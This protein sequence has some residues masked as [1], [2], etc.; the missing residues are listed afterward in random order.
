MTFPIRMIFAVPIVLSAIVFAQ[1]VGPAT[2]PAYTMSWFGNSFSG[3]DAWMQRQIL[4]ACVLPDG[5]VAAISYWDERHKEIG[6]YKDGQPVGRPIA[7][8]GAAIATDGKFLYAASR[9]SNP[10]I[11]GIRRLNLDGTPAPWPTEVRFADEGET[12]LVR[13]IAAGGGELFICA[14]MRNEVRV[15]NLDTG[16][17]KRSLPI[18]AA[19]RI[20]FAPTGTLWIGP[21]EY[22][23]DGTPTGR[24]LDGITAGALAIDPDGRLVVADAGERHQ[25]IVYDISGE[26]QPREVA[27]LGIRGGVFA[28]PRPGTMGDDRLLIPTGVGVD[29]DGNIYVSSEDLLR[30]YAPGGELRWQLECT[31]FTD[32][33]DFDPASD[34]RDIYTARH[35]YRHVE[36]Q[37]PGKDWQWI[38]WTADPRRFPEL[39]FGGQPGEVYVRRI[40]GTL[41][42]FSIG[43]EVIVHRQQP[44]SESFI[45][46][47]AYSRRGVPGNQ[48]RPKAAPER[49]RY[50]WCDANGN[51]LVESG[52]FSLY[53]PDAKPGQVAY[54]I[55]VDERGDLWEPQGS[56]GL[57]HI[58]LASINGHG[59]PIY[60]LSRAKW[61]ERPED[62]SYVARAIYV[63]DADTMYLS[64]YTADLPARPNEHWGGAGRVIIRYED[65]S[66]PT[67]RAA[68]RM[69]LPESALNIRAITVAH[70]A[71]LVF[72]GEMESMKIFTYR[73]ADGALLGTIEP[74]ADLVG[75]VGWLDLTAGIRA[76]TRKNG[77]VLLL[78]EE[79]WSQKQ[80]IYTITP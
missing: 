61:P 21:A 80:L 49:Q 22:A 29:A 38:G 28:G 25:V 34:G 73:A 12:Y 20:A 50:F 30:S 40:N 15:H 41:Y 17:Y 13:G 45:P 65:W 16:E 10:K 26:D 31:M 57:L 66:K 78:C 11:P 55:Y 71:G 76:F 46:C 2:M 63:A 43:E 74:D 64:G 48:G 53:G 32:C 47:T 54:S 68:A 14:S 37:S 39:A 79:V 4:N 24:K 51:G 1:P 52:E 5:T 3:K 35:H 18:P 7:G 75:R 70:E 59:V 27:T 56:A 8:G 58:P 19:E 42:R 6:F 9:S 23:L 44:G 77:E 60:D 62:L 69:L 36:N 67:R 33:A 72:A